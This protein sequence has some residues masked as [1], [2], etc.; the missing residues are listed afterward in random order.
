ML[1]KIDVI[2]ASV[3]KRNKLYNIETEVLVSA[4]HL[5]YVEATKR[6]D[7]SRGVQFSTFADRWI[8]GMI[9]NEVRSILGNKK[10][11][12]KRPVQDHDYDFSLYGDSGYGAA[13]MEG[14]LDLHLMLCNLPFTKAK[15]DM[16]RQYIYGMS[17]REVGEEY[18]YSTSHASRIIY[19]MRKK[20]ALNNIYKTHWS[21]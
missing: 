18:G 2:V 13:K 6:F 9:M 21:N 5:G 12:S 17:A 16:F 14:D 10:N 20:L 11:K 3:M 15:K 4:A 19:E 8:V 1:K 7:E